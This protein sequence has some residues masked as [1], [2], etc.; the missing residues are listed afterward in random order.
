ML[1]PLDLQHIQEALCVLR[2]D[3]FYIA[4]KKCVFMTPK[5]L[6]LGYV[7]SGDGI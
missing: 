3:E 6:F 2:R 5:V 1:I 7:V 4:I